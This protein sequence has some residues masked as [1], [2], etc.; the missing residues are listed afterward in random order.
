MLAGC[1]KEV[2]VGC[3]GSREVQQLGKWPHTKACKDFPGFL[4]QASSERQT[5]E[6][7]R[8]GKSQIWVGLVLKGPYSQEAIMPGLCCEDRSQVP[9]TEILNTDSDSGIWWPKT[10]RTI[11]PVR[12]R[13]AVCPCHWASLHLDT[14]LG[15]MKEKRPWG[16]REIAMVGNLNM[17][18]DWIS[19]RDWNNLEKI[20]NIN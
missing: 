7:Y 18:F 15:M 16:R 1:G 10:R 19:Q 20:R 8:A 13:R 6:I 17:T 3:Q 12:W 11:S 9:W 14:S 4:G 5:S 2:T